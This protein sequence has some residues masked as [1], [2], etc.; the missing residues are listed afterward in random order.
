MFAGDLQPPLDGKKA[1]QLVSKITFLDKAACA[2]TNISYI[3]TATHMPNVTTQQSASKQADAFADWSTKEDVEGFAAMLKEYR[4]GRCPENEFRRYRLHNGAYSVR[5]SEDYSM[6]RVKMPAG[7]VTPSQLR[8]FSLLSE[9]FSIGSIHISTRENIQMHWVV[10]D[11]VPEV[12][13]RLSGMGL[14]ARETCGGTIHNVVCAPTSGVCP[15]ES[16]DATLYAEATA[17]FFLRNPMTQSLPRKFK[18]TYSCCHKHGRTHTLDVGIIPHTAVVDGQTRRGFR[19]FVGGGLGT[20]SLVGHLLEEFTPEENLMHTLIAIVQLYDRLGERKNKFRS[21]L[22]YLVQL[23]GWNKFQSMI[24]KERAVVRIT[25]SA[26]VRLSISHVAQDIQRP[27]RVSVENETARPGYARWSSANTFVQKQAEY[28]TVFIT[29]EA[30]D[31]SASHLMDVADIIQ[32][33]SAEGIGRL[34]L[35]QNICIRYVH[36]DDMSSLYARLLDAGL[37]RPGALTMASTIGCVSTTSCNLALVNAHRLAKEVQRKLLEMGL[38]QDESLRGSSIK[39]SGCPNS[40]GQHAIATIGFYGGGGRVGRDQYPLY[41]MSIGGRDDDLGAIGTQVMRIPA[42]RV[43]PAILR[44]LDVF[45]EV[46]KD[47]DDLKSWIHR[48]CQ[49]AESTSVADIRGILA[50]LAEAPS[51]DQDPD[52]YTDYGSNTSY[53]LKIGRGCTA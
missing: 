12:L 38:D 47:D 15:N 33:Y 25:Q 40:C 6:I 39:I 5:L 43:I 35:G 7:H 16:F 53:Q 11:D 17:R 9:Q 50:P 45:R 23:M 10:L 31:I 42:K 51:K 22:R 52:F 32:E 29:L 28:R 20:K 49:G 1:A 13:R 36:Q 27:I 21:R 41:N 26:Q 4:E 14:T 19:I 48:V 30:G 46:R 24:L 44:L 2:N 3:L 37:A 18:I 8:G 34:G